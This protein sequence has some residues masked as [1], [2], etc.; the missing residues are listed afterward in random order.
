M[1]LQ[2]KLLRFDVPDLSQAASTSNSY[3]RIRINMEHYIQGI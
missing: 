2:P 1:L 3:S